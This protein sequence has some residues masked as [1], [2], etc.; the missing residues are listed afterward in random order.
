LRYGLRFLVAPDLR[1]IEATLAAHKHPVAVGIPGYILPQDTDGRL[2]LRYDSPVRSISSEPAGSV[3]IHDDGRS[4]SGLQAYTLRGKHWGRFRLVVTYADGRVQSIGYRT[5]KPET[6][7][8]ADMGRFLFHQQWFDEPQDPF[9]RSPSVIT[10]DNETGKQV[11]QDARVW[12]AGLS[13][14]AGAEQRWRSQVW[15]AQELVFLS[16]RPGSGFYL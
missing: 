8:V 9:H 12:I 5:V 15:R 3:T 10:Y 14:E 16:A 6:E 1:H 2:F 13:D 7:V 11:T 4:R